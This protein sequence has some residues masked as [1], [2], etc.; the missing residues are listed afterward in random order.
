MHTI[1]KFLV[2]QLLTNCIF[3]ISEIVGKCAVDHF[4]ILYSYIV[5]HLS[6]RFSGREHINSIQIKCILVHFRLEFSIQWIEISRLSNF[7]SSVRP[8]F[9]PFL[10]FSLYMH[11]FPSFNWEHRKRHQIKRNRF[12]SSICYDEKYKAMKSHP[13]NFLCGMEVFLNDRICLLWQKREEFHHWI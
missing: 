9:F 3:G 4:S 1:N 13:W 12:L 6:S 7:P 10:V 8:N 2:S 11:C 5:C